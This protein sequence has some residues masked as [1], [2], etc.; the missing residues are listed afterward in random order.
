[1]TNAFFFSYFLL[2]YITF[3]NLIWL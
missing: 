2:M 3:K 1:M